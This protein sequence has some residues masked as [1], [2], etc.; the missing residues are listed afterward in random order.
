MPSITDWIAAGVSGRQEKAKSR[1]RHGLKM[2]I[3][4]TLQPVNSTKR[5]S[6]KLNERNHLRSARN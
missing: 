2:P 4:R 3:K 6:V 1:Q 5:F